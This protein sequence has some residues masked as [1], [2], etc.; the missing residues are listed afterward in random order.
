MA[1]EDRATRQPQKIPLGRLVPSRRAVRPAMASTV[2]PICRL[3]P[4]NTGRFRRLRASPD[5]S[6]PMVNSSMATP[7][8]ATSLMDWLSTMPSREGPHNTPV[9]KNPTVAV[10]FILLHTRLTTMESRKMMTSSSSSSKCIC[11]SG[12]GANPHVMRRS[13]TGWAC[14]LQGSYHKKRRPKPQG[15]T[16][17]LV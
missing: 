2:R 6:I 13:R 4:R 12:A 8:S 15:S 5:S 16:Y 14:R 17:G 7:S 1:E 11:T 3:P 10:S 9:S